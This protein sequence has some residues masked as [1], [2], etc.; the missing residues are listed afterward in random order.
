MPPKESEFS[1]KYIAG[2]WQTRGAPSETPSDHSP[3]GLFVAP[4]TQARGAP[5]ETP[6]KQS[7][8]GK[9]GEPRYDVGKPRRV[10]VRAQ[11]IND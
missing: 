1:E 8:E 10:V 3:E 5:P 4:G 6:S 11:I 7:T 2:S 9:A